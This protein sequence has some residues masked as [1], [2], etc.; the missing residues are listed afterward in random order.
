MESVK[1]VIEEPHVLFMMSVPV[2]C[3]AVILRASQFPRPHSE[4]FG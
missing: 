1:P 3:H 4:A 2:K